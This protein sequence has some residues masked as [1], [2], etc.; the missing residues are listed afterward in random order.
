M[1][2]LTLAIINLIFY[3]KIEIINK[4]LNIYD[5]PNKA[6]KL[7]VKP[8]AVSGGGLM[9]VNILILFSYIHF[10]KDTNSLFF[11]N[12]FEFFINLLFIL[13]FWLIGLLDDK[14]EFNP[15]KKITARCFNLNWSLEINKYNKYG[16]KGKKIVGAG[17]L[18]SL[19]SVA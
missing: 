1:I 19:I 6:R 7:Q 11:I 12:Q 13:S 5:H 17:L 9:L 14:F 2:F 3:L 4:K 16:M 15:I 18:I 10:Y 8:I